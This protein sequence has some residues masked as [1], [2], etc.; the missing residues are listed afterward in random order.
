MYSKFKFIYIGLNLGV[1]SFLL[2]P[3]EDNKIIN[4]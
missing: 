4:K 1:C 2:N 3:N